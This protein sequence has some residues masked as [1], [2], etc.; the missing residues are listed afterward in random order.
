MFFDLSRIASLGAIFYLV[1]DIIIHW[2][3]LRYLRKDVGAKAG[4]VVTAILLDAIA[5]GAFVLMKAQSDPMIIV[6]A[7]SGIGIIFGFEKFYLRQ[8]RE[9]DEGGPTAPPA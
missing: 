6:I 8:V 2:G 5:L 9:P 3:V 7:L 4:I 1:M